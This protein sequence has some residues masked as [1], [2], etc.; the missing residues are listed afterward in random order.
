MTVFVF[1]GVVLAAIAIV[2]GKRGVWAASAVFLASLS[3]AVLAVVCL[4]LVHAAEGS[5]LPPDFYKSCHKYLPCG[6]HLLAQP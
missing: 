2:F 5:H 6:S 4:L 3:F 1:G